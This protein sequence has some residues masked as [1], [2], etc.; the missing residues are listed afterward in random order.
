M[1]RLTALHVFSTIVEQGSLSAAAERLDMSR[2][3]VTR[4]LAELEDW[5]DTRLLHRTTRSMSLTS[6]GEETL[7]VARNL[8]IMADSLNDIRHKNQLQLKGQLRI[9]SSYS[10][11]DSFLVEV[12][13]NFV[14]RWPEVSVDIVSTDK[15]VNLVD[16]RIDLAIRIT[17]DLADNVVS[18]KIGECRSVLCASPEYLKK[19]DIPIDIE[20]LSQHNCLSFTYFKHS[21]WSFDGPSGSLSVSIC[22]NISANVSE[23]L[24]TSTL[25]GNGISLQPLAVA[26]SLLNSG[27]LVE[28]LPEWKPKTLGVHLVYATRKQVTPLLRAFIDFLSE[29]MQN[30]PDW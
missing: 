13:G 19:H 3:K 1:D 15:A 2:A 21:V 16:S 12:I 22:G 7:E 27:K 23:V 26:R 4:F 6:A 8:L 5:M 9:T 14:A 20:A 17:N 30:S 11:I 18:K 24:L 25:L 28:L 10:V 29:H